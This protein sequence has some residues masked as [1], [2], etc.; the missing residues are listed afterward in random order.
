MLTLAKTKNLTQQIYLKIF[1]ISD[2]HGNKSH[3]EIKSGSEINLD[4]TDK[5]PFDEVADNAI[6]QLMV[7]NLNIT[8]YLQ[9][10]KMKNL[11]PP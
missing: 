7:C 11:L 5:T 9:H 2:A 3:T 1:S 6:N 4:Q 8:N 10:Q